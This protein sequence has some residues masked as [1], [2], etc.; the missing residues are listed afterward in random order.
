[1]WKKFSK[2][3]LVVLAIVFMAVDYYPL[4]V[5]AS[6][7]SV[8]LS[9]KASNQPE[10]YLGYTLSAKSLNNYELNFTGSESKITIGSGTS[11]FNSKLTFSRW[12][13]VNFSLNLPLASTGNLGTG[14]LAN[15]R[16]SF[17]N[18]NYAISY[19]PTAPRH[20]PSV[21]SRS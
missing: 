9:V 1:M 17:S 12:N 16:L 15:S 3:L 19:Q 20:P 6:M 2:V 13:E 5:S 21:S 11:T 7:A 4:V 10:T 14:T 18:T 8:G